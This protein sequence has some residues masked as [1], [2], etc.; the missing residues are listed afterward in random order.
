MPNDLKNVANIQCENCHGPGGEH[1]KS[2]ASFAI[3]IPTNTG[4]CTQCH[5]E[6]THHIKGAEWNNSMHAVT[7]RDPS[8]AG[9]QACVGCHTANGFMGRM[10]GAATVDTTYGA[11]NC[12]T[13]HEPHGQTAPSSAAHLI[14]NMGSVKLADGTNVTTAGEGSLCMSCHQSRQNAKAYAATAAGSA[15]FGPHDGPQADMLEGANGFTYGTNIPSSAHQ[16]VV[17]DTCVDC[18]MQ[19]VAATDPA[20]LQA[21]GHTFKASITPAG[22]NT[23]EDLVGA[24]QNCHGPEI[25]SFNFQLMDYDG[26]GVI[27][28]VQTE[29][30]HLLDRLSAMLPPA[31]QPKTALNIDSTWTQPQLEA[32]YNWLFVNNDGSRGVHNTAY[33][34]GLL[35]ASIANL[36]MT[37]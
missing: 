16:W 22:S 7:T 21:G 9:R 35:K 32:A 36:S 26:D 31:G 6:P 1:A 5:D 15:H 11:I 25:T 3:S 30:Q 19:T 23:P 17:K 37:Q 24:C 34:V 27:D 29:V 28:G 33:A 8:G 10:T 4:T 14:R 20:F 18:H 13:C 12:Q 2:A